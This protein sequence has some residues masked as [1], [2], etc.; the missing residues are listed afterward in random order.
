MVQPSGIRHHFNTQV[1]ACHYPAGASP[2]A[3]G[4]TVGPA[5]SPSYML[6]AQSTCSAV[7][8]IPFWSLKLTLLPPTSTPF[9]MLFPPPGAPSPAS[10]KSVSTYPSHLKCLF[11]K[12]MSLAFRQ[13]QIPL[14]YV[15]HTFCGCFPFGVFYFY[16]F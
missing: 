14:E 6:H 8:P 5:S 1:C 3:Q 10:T 12:A 11:P 9:S 15:C 2:S 7:A 13:G 16:F 4:P